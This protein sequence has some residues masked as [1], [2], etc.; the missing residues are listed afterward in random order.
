MEIILCNAPPLVNSRHVEH[1]K[2]T[3][4]STGKHRISWSYGQPYIVGVSGKRFEVVIN[5]SSK[6]SR[7]KMNPCLEPQEHFYIYRI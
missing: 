7:M 2:T 4:F 6:A 3:L 1:K 5:V